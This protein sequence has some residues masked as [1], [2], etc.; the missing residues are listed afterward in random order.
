[1]RAAAIPL[2]AAAALSAAGFLGTS[3][4][5][6]AIKCQNQYQVI[7]GTGLVPTPYCED[8]YLAAVAREYGI[9]VSGRAIRASYNLK[10]SVCYRVGHDH[11][12]NNIC[13]GL[14]HEDYKPGKIIIP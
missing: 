3:P 11:R 2:F 14:R 6:A 4:A 8:N 1:M 13:A 12:L 10:R 9:G 7:A 5:E